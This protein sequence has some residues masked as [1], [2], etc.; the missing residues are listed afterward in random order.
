M[1]LTFSVDLR[2]SS[3]ETVYSVIVYDASVTDLLLVE[4]GSVVSV[5]TKIL[6]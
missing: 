3:V 6:A 1:K 5:S 4:S 2:S